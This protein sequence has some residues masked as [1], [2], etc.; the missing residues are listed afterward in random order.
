MISR[1]VSRLLN[2]S[3]L[4]FTL[5]IM[6]LLLLKNGVHPIGQD[7]ISWIY[8]AGRSFPQ[9]ENYLSYS[10]FPVLMAKILA[11]PDFV[12]WWVLFL[13]LTAVFYL[14]VFT[15]INKAAKSEY[16]KWVMI[17]LSFPFMITPLY[18][19]GHYD[20]LTIGGAVVA[21]LQNRKIFVFVGAF[22]AISANPE[23]AVFTSACVAA[24][25]LGSRLP[26]HKYVAKVWL[27]LSITAFILLRIFLGSA[28]DGNRAKI[29]FGQLRDV[30]LNSAG[31]LHL[32]IFSVFSV[33]W[34]ILGLIYNSNSGPIRNKFVLL[35]VVVIPVL[36]S[37]S[38]LDRTRIGVAV[39]ALPLILLLK[40]LMD[41]NSLEKILKLNITQ[42][43]L[44]YALLL[45]PTVIIDTDGSLRLPYLEL[46]N[47]F[48]V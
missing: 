6:A 38:I 25:A 36:L 26:W 43:H 19:L 48:I 33:G 17:F 1:Q 39:G 45:T 44:F 34:L 13:L 24:L 31:L 3:N 21:G 2:A 41:S 5:I 37:L 35:A 14:I 23:Q 18:Y 4:N 42:N 27:T 12:L 46:I 7:W 9:P 22:L 40:Q 30:V 20:L 15:S 28:E 32:I 47:K 11:Y 10:L 29:I 8:S 16:K